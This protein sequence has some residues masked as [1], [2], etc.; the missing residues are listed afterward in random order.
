MLDTVE[1]QLTLRKCRRAET[2]NNMSLNTVEE[3]NIE[4]Q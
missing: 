2:K 3:F 4:R 1:T